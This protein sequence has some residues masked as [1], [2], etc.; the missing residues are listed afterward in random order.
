MNMSVN[1]ILTTHEE[2]GTD[3]EAVGGEGEGGEGGVHSCL[4]YCFLSFSGKE[5]TSAVL[6]LQ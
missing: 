1:I 3:M 5:E 2:A 4:T 6:G